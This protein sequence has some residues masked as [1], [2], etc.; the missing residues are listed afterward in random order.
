MAEKTINPYLVLAAA[1]VIPGS[2]H[3][4]VGKQQRGLVFLF[5]M[6]VLGWTSWHVM[7]ETGSFVLRHAGAL[8][9]YGLSVLD[10]YKLARVDRAVADFKP[11]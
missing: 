10:A 1:L 4:L 11:E 6:L 7:P 2:G 3:L 9:V 5:F 8:L